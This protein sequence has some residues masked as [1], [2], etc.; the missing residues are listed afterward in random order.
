[1]VRKLSCFF[2]RSWSRGDVVEVTLRIRS[3]GLTPNET[4]ADRPRWVHFTISP[5]VDFADDR[6]ATNPALRSLWFTHHNV[7]GET[8]MLPPGVTIPV[9]SPSTK[10]NPAAETPRRP[11]CFSPGGRNLIPDV[12]ARTAEC[13][14]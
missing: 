13:P 7:P 10:T 5:I 14:P 12:S 6:A 4:A 8:L 3:S 11:V 2:I 9:S 1:M